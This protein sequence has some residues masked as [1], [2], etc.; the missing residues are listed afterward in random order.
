MQLT[1]ILWCRNRSIM[2]IL[3]HSQQGRWTHFCRHMLAIAQRATASGNL[4][5]VITQN[6]TQQELCHH[7]SLGTHCKNLNTQSLL[8]MAWR[9]DQAQ[10]RSSPKTPYKVKTLSNWIQQGTKYRVWS[11]RSNQFAHRSP[12][13]RSMPSGS[14]SQITNHSR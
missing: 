4:L 13:R 1:T 9:Q 10:S 3:M 6:H 8:R 5:T 11:A 14:K 7:C 2:R 12:T